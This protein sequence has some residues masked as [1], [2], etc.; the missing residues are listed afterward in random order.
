MS[1]SH[2]NKHAAD[3]EAS[4]KCHRKPNTR[5]ILHSEYVSTVLNIKQIYAIIAIALNLVQDDIQLSDFI[6]LI[7]GETFY[8]SKKLLHYFPKN[9]ASKTKEILQEIYFYSCPDKYSDKVSKN[10]FL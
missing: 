7:D 10:N 8:N 9:V 6:N 3:S 5:E 2:L 1:K 4:L